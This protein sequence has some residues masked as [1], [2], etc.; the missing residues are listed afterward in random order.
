[1]ALHQ[2]KSETPRLSYLSVAPYHNDIFS[3][4]TSLNSQ[5]KEV[6]TLVAVPGATSS[7]CQ[8]GR[9]L[10]EN[11]R[12]LWPEANPGITTYLVGVYDSISGITGFI[13]PNSPLYTLFST[14]KVYS[15]PQSTDPGPGAML[16]QGMPILTNSSVEAGTFVSAGTNV[17]AGI[18]VSAGRDLNAAR[19]VNVLRNIDISGNINLTL[20]R[21]IMN[22]GNTG[23]ANMASGTVVNTFRKLT[24]T[25][26]NCKVG[27]IIMLTYAGQNQVG[28]LSAEAIANG[29][30]QIVS[31]NTAD[32]G[33]VMWFIVN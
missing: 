25:A 8:K 15:L 20:G 7:T 10:R 30:F 5:Y 29:S 13:D 14:D 18:D 22:S 27:S 33:T 1:M 12:K 16:D 6:G 9:V 28:V 17:S 24:V 21:L 4:K 3:Y 31:S 26:T 19:D 32:A 23:I 11:G 2:G